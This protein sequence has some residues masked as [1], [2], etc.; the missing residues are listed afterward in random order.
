MQNVLDWFLSFIPEEEW[1]KRR[2][3]IEAAIEA[4]QP[5]VITDEA[6][7]I[8][9][10]TKGDNIGLYLYL[11]ECTLKEPH[12]CEPDRGARVTPLFERLEE[13]LDALKKIPG[14]EDR[15][16]RMV[17]QEK[18]S[19]DSSLFEIF[20]ALLWIRNGWQCEFIP[21]SK[22]KTPD[23]LAHRGEER[24]FIECKRLAQY[25]DYSKEEKA[26]WYRLWRHYR[27]KIAMPNYV[28]DFT[29]H[30]ELRDLPDDFLL[31]VLPPRL[32]PGLV[33]KTESLDTT[34]R[35]VDFQK[36]RGHLA[37]NYVRYP[38]EQLRQLISGKKVYDRGFI[39]G[40]QGALVRLGDE[41]GNTVFV[42]SIDSAYGAFW[43]CDAPNSL[44]S[45]A[46]DVQRHLDRATEQLPTGEKCVIHIGI[47]TNDGSVVE[48]IR[49]QR[50]FR[51][52]QTFD[53][54]GKDVQAVYCNLF[55][56]Y[57]H[58]SGISY[59]DETSHTF[60]QF[61]EGKGPIQSKTLIVPWTEIANNVHWKRER[62]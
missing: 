27:S 51:T 10:D 24:F 14:I 17:L 34:I 35:S 49:R 21:E 4:C 1:Q 28:F 45:K 6:F 33:M 20:T 48:E 58:P 57:A 47:E 22:R 40:L 59:I 55:Q 18:S 53:I 11:V 8:V 19:P 62:P 37:Q 26:H 52:I 13:E 29:L 7:D 30:A 5:V 43:Q 3:A 38:S 25:S 41:I 2:T 42:D 39:S 31:K 54:Q 61:E 32:Y 9:L 23:L 50:M 56:S 60:A 36:I 12:K 46:R 15:I 44:S 16:K